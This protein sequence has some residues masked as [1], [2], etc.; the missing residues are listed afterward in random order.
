[1]NPQILLTIYRKEMLDMIRDRRTL[2]SMIVV[3]MVAM[4]LIMLA[5]SYFMSSME[6]KAR[7]ESTTVGVGQGAVAPAAL[8]A[9]RG[10]G[11][12]LVP[13]ADLRRAV[14]RKEVAAA[15]EEVGEGKVGR[16]FVIYADLTRPASQMAASSIRTALDGWKEQEIRRRLKELGAP[17][18]VLTPFQVTRVNIAPE[19]KMA[20][21]FWGSILGYI[22]LLLMFSGGMYPAIDMTAGEKERR[23]LEVLLSSPASRTEIVFGKLLAATTAIFSTAVLTITSLIVTLRRGGFGQS[24]A[25]F[26]EM[27]SRVPLDAGTIAL[28]FAALLPTAVMAASVMIA[29]ALFARSFKEAQS[30]LT[31]LVLLVAVPAVAGLLPGMKL[32]P[33]LAAIPIYNVSQLI[34]EIFLGEFSPFLFTVTSATNFLYAAVVFFLAVRIFKN[35]RVLFRS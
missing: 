2:I 3:P 12:R 15:L 23:T 17:E 22:V 9:L 21:R 13:A 19:R 24:S 14:E 29:V 7:E 6:S 25:E 1:V 11:F 33:A 31:P 10:A 16:K 35:E 27:V 20:G 18:T 26:R 5:M 8:E 32:T 30:Y 34:K 4:P 28:V